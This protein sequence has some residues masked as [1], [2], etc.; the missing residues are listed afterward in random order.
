MKTLFI[1]IAALTSTVFST[2]QDSF[3]GLKSVLTAREW[4]RAGLD[5][6]S[7]DQIGVIDAALIRY[8]LSLAPKPQPEAA[9]ARP[10]VAPAP[11]PAAATAER[12]RGWLERFGLPVG[13]DDDWK[14]SP[15]LKATVVA[16]DGGNRFRLDNGQIWEG[17]EPIPYELVG[18]EI[19]IY[20]RPNHRFTFSL[21]GKNTAARIYRVR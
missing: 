5:Q 14:N 2:A 13:G 17:F 20:A 11:A 10:E 16:W 12:K 8:Q 4:Q 3:P 1:V 21:D 9:P 18:K 7:P 19:E 6:L 15:P